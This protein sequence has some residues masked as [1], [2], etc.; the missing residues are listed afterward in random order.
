MA[1]DAGMPVRDLIGNSLA[2]KKIDIRRYITDEVGEPTLKDIIAE[3][4]KPGRDP[5]A[6]F[7]PPKFRDDVTKLEDVREGMKLE[8]VVTNVTAFGAFVDIGVHQDGLVHL[9]ELSDNYVT[10]AASVVKAGDRLTVTVIGVDRARGRISLSAK[11]RPSAA[12]SAGSASS[13]SAKP[14]TSFAPSGRSGFSCNPFA[15]L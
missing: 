12:S 2:V 13:R 11:T 14:R 4:V 1:A 7:E 3:L 5:R 9:S 8:G 6:T 15:N 10:D